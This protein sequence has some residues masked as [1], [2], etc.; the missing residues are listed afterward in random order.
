MNSKIRFFF[1]PNTFPGSWKNEAFS[2]DSL[3]DRNRT[4]KMTLLA[5]YAAPAFHGSFKNEP[6]ISK[7]ILLCTRMMKMRR[8]CF[9]WNKLYTDS[10]FF[11]QYKN[12]TRCQYEK[13]KAKL[14]PNTWIFENANIRKLS[15]IIQINIPYTPAC[16]MKHRINTHKSNP[17]TA[18]FFLIFFHIR[19]DWSFVNV[20]IWWEKLISF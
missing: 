15:T 12:C 8:R 14:S 1:Q 5:T 17:E 10:L 16:Q 3:V 6:L 18:L 20:A 7:Y 4:T 2:M 9:Y 13:R 19:N 11:V